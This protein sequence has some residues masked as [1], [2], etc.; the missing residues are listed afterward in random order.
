MS[1]YLVVFL[2]VSVAAWL[3]FDDARKEYRHLREVEAQNRMRLDEAERELR[4]EEVILQRLRTD[5]A[6]V[7]Q[8]IRRRLGYA[9]PDDVIFKFE[10]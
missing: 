2:G 5:P 7:E 3:Y 10:Q 6:Y 8:Q 4:R 9:K 1:L